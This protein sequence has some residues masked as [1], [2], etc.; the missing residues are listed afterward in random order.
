MRRLKK[1]RGKIENWAEA[2]RLVVN[3]EDDEILNFLVSIIEEN[4]TVP[5]ILTDES[6]NISS[7][8]NLDSAV[9]LILFTWPTS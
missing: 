4:S 2:T 8:I 1:R 6:G 3:E 7:F 5:V 9:S